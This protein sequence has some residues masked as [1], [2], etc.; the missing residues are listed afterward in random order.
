MCL[1]CGCRSSLDAH[2]DGRHITLADLAA[3]ADATGISIL[4]AAANLRDTLPVPGPLPALYVDIDGTLAFQPEGSI[5]AVN[6]RFGTRY[7]AAEAGT[8]P[9]WGTLPK[10]QRRWERAAQAVIDANLAPDTLAI[11]VLRRAVA[12]G[13]PLTV[14]TERDPGLAGVTRAWCEFWRVPADQVAV[15]GPG[16]KAD[17]LALHDPDAPAILVDDN[18]AN[19]KYARPGVQVWQPA[20]PY[21]EPAEGVFRFD[22]WNQAAFAL[23]LA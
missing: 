2:G 22:G 23:G 9:W 1:D 17:L 6:A 10:E 8:Y 13:Y 18:P 12:H 16:G 14:C 21:N 15:V 5:L 20:R 4:Q 11:D 3:A 7:L 19:V